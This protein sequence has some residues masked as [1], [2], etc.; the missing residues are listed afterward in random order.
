M[1][2]FNNLGLTL[3]MTLIF[4][5]S[6]AKRVKTKSPKVFRAISCVGRRYWEKL[7]GRLLA[8]PHQILNRVKTFIS[9]VNQNMEENRFRLLYQ[10]AFHGTRTL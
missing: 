1:V 7:V 3:G 8:S 9:S 5:N 10:I 6:M 2:Q 4:Y